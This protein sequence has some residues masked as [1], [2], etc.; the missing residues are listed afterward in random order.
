LGA[1]LVDQL[2]E[3]AVGI[4]E[5]I[6]DL[7]LGALFD[8]DGAEGLVAA[9]ARSDGAGEEVVAAGVIHRQAPNVSF[10]LVGIRI[11]AQ[12]MGEPVPSSRAE[13]GW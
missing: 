8:E 3:R 7:L 4:S 6:S 5:L 1:E 2:A 11:A 13:C 9:L 12:F 10:F